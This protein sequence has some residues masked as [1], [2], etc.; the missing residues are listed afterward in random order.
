MNLFIIKSVF[1]TSNTEVV[2]DLLKQDWILLNTYIKD[3]ESFYCLGKIHGNKK[4]ASFDNPESI[5]NCK[6]KLERIRSLAE[7]INSYQKD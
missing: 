2:N 4:I 5:K 1:E 3:G 7:A 6:T